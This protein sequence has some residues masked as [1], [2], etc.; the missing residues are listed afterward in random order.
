MITIYNEIISIIIPEGS[1]STYK[2]RECNPAVYVSH[3]NA[4]EYCTWM[5][6]LSEEREWEAA[7]R[8]NQWYDKTPYVQRMNCSLYL[9][10]NINDTINGDDI[11]CANLWG[12]GKFTN[13]VQI[14]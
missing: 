5:K 3:K 8:Y 13:T 14:M 10:N 9:W 4:A 11:K 12:T 1:T 2:Y 7:A 6:I